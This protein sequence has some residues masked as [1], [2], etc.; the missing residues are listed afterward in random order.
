MSSD[1]FSLR[2]HALAKVMIMQDL[3][4]IQTNVFSAAET[5]SNGFF[6][7]GKIHNKSLVAFLGAIR[8]LRG[9]QHEN[10][11]TVERGFAQPQPLVRRRR[12]MTDESYYCVRSAN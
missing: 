2:L 12:A 11:G 4:V 5:G 9:Q 6:G 1:V 7:I 10:A 8:S 3:S